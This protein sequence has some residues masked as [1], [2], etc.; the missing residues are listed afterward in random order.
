MHSIDSI[1]SHH[2]TVLDLLLICLAIWIISVLVGAARKW[3]S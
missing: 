1:I 2:I 3:R